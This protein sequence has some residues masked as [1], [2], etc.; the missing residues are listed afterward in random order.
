MKFPAQILFLALG[1]GI[2][3][4]LRV[5]VYYFAEKYITNTLPYGTILVNIAGSLLIG[6]LWGIFQQNGIPPTLKAFVFI[7]VLGGFTTFSSFALDS[8]NILQ[9]GKFLLFAAYFVLNNVLGISACF[10]GYY[11]SKSFFV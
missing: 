6:L 4:L 9:Q 1:G 7:G 10:I 5:L 11:T 3:T 8:F 2:G